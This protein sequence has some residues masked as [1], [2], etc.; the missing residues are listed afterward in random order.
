MLTPGKSFQ[1][2][3]GV[4]A[5]E[6]LE[7]SKLN[8]KTALLHDDVDEEIFLEQPQGFRHPVMNI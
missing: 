2:F 1:F 8:V 6:D 3:L 5:A 7:L 4:V